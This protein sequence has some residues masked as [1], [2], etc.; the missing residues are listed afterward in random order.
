VPRDAPAHLC[1]GYV[2]TG[3]G[4]DY[5]TLDR[6]A[7]RISEGRIAAAPTVSSMA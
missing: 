1:P 3:A 6:V 7:D 4:A 2:A 5:P